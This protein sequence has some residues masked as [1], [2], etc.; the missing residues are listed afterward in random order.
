M[1]PSAVIGI[2]VG[3]TRIKSVITPTGT[4]LDELVSPTPANIGG[5][6]GT[7][8]EGLLRDHLARWADREPGLGAA[9]AVATVEVVVPGVVD[10]VPG[11]GRYSSNLGWRDLD[12]RS[13]I[14]REVDLPLRRPRRAPRAAGRAPV[15]AA[16][17]GDRAGSLGAGV[18]ALEVNSP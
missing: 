18:L 7:V 5:S 17:L 6:I 14:G 2:D 9:R 12:L 8:V 16:A 11:I 1:T 10:D 15:R 4:V 13:L 3:G